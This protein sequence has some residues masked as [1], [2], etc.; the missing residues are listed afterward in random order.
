[1]YSTERHISPHGETNCPLSPRSG[2]VRDA[3]R[4][5][6]ACVDPGAHPG[7]RGRPSNVHV[8]GGRLGPQRRALA[9]RRIRAGQG[10]WLECEADP[11]P[12]LPGHVP[13]QARPGPPRSTPVVGESR[14][15][16]GRSRLPDEKHGGRG[17]PVVISHKD[18]SL[19]VAPG[20]AFT[21]EVVESSTPGAARCRIVTSTHEHTGT[22]KIDIE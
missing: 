12:L 7:A 22:C 4:P 19:L 15:R 1:M 5:S 2:A 10:R 20:E 6:R 16:V 11:R 9:V 14:E 8:R 21:I 13:R 18:T 3:S 17:A